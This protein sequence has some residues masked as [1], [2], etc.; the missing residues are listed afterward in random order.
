MFVSHNVKIPLSI[1]LSLLIFVVTLGTGAVL[2]ITGYAL[3]RKNM[4]NKYI[5]MGQGLTGTVVGILKGEDLERYLAEGI[6]DHYQESLNLLD[7]LLL[8]NE[9]NY[10]YVFK[11][12]PEGSLFVFDAG[13]NDPCPL[14]YLDP[15]NEGFPEEEKK[16]FFEGEEIP[17]QKYNS[18]LAGTVLTVHTPVRYGDGSVAK[19]F[20]VAAD[21]SIGTLDGEYREYLMYLS[22]ISFSVA[23]VFAL[24]HRYIVHHLVILPVSAMAKATG[25]FLIAN[26]HG[27]DQGISLQDLAAVSVHTGDE[28]QVLAESLRDMEKRIWAYIRNLHQANH[29]TSTDPLTGLLDRETLY[30]NVNLFIHRFRN[31]ARRHAFWILDLD[32]F[33]QMND[34]YSRATGDELLKDCA[35]ALRKVFRISDEIARIGGDEFAVFSPNIGSVEAVEQKASRIR[36]VFGEIKPQ[37]WANGITASIGIALFSDEDLTYDELFQ[38][39]DKALWEVK[40]QGRDGFRI[41]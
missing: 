26:E 36:K 22:I 20:Y 8:Y 24:V 10:L 25:K 15:W 3:Y 39:T 32:R 6:D 31:P 38:R 12:V 16:P 9:I 34:T 4:E 13:E 29:K 5:S 18:N 37:S 2:T 14:G 7:N 27:E 17:P 21:F 1:R 41:G 30:S 19:G 40:A 11:S 33:R 35:A 28:L 23:L